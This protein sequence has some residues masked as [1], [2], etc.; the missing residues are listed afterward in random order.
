MCVSCV[1]WR[2]AEVTL[3]KPVFGLNLDEHLQHTNRLISSVIEQSIEA[4][5]SAEYDALHEEVHSGYGCAYCYTS[6]IS[7]GVRVTSLLGDFW[8]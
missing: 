7:G 1:S 5:S 8:F 3:L 6:T 2:G 4:L